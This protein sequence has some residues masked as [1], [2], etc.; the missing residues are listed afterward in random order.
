MVFLCEAVQRP[1]K[2]E[3]ESSIRYGQN[4]LTGP[5]VADTPLTANAAQEPIVPRL[6]QRRPLVRR[7]RKGR[8]P[9]APG[10]WYYGVTA[11]S[12]G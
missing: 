12:L 1:S 7:P 9:I 6:P 3:R 10:L 8:F 11:A 2:P 4:R 5:C